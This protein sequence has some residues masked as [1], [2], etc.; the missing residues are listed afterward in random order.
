MA[1]L[2]R[3]LWG[4][5]LAVGVVVISLGANAD[6]ATRDS[7]RIAKYGY[8]YV[9]KKPATY[10]VAGTGKTGRYA[11]CSAMFFG[12]NA[13]LEFEAKNSKAWAFYVAY[14]DWEH[15][16]GNKKLA[17][18]SGSQ[19]IQIPS[20][21]YGGSM[22]SGMSHNL[23]AGK[24]I[25]MDT[26]LS[27]M[28]QGEPISFFDDRGNRLVTFPNAGDDLTNAFQ[29]AIKCSVANAPKF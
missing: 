26:L 2:S 1:K 25:S 29:R 21:L 13:S 22:I 11:L 14:E 23:Q 6:P 9:V 24:P 12:K 7:D 28:S 8:W 19:K 20:A 4:A 18:S 27:F 5:V 3:L 15:P 17:I 10:V 16:F